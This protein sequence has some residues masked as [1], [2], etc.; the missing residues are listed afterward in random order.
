MDKSAKLLF[1][2][3]NIYP[4]DDG[5]KYDYDYQ[6]IIEDFDDAKLW[7]ILDDEKRPSPAWDKFEDIVLEHTYVL[8]EDAS[9]DMYVRL[10]T[11]EGKASR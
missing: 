3:E 5:N 2:V 6:S 10:Q 4:P 7:K 9:G 8:S 11:G 1:I